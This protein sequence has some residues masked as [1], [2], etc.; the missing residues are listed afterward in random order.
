M[1]TLEADNRWFLKFDDEREVRRWTAV[2]PT[3][4]LGD[5]ETAVEAIELLRSAG[6]PQY[7]VFMDVRFGHRTDY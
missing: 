5:V 4:R 7:V 1:T 3:G 2:G 6:A